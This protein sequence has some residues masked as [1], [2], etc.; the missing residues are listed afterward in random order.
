M[1]VAEDKS[2]EQVSLMTLHSAKGLEFDLVFLPGWEEEIFPSRRTLEENGIKGLEEERRL[3]YVGLTRAKKRVIISHV[4][5]RLV[6]GSWTHAIPSRFAAELPEQHV[7]RASESGM[8]GKSSGVAAFH[9][10]P[11]SGFT[12]G[13]YPP[14]PK[15]VVI[16]SKAVVIEEEFSLDFRKGDRVF[17][18]KFGYGTVTGRDGKKLDI[19]FDQAGTKKVMADF[20]VPEDQAG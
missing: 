9:P 12:K 17:H 13:H 5:S 1:D 14:R 16:D 7:Q 2:Q 15:P 10:A 20:V 4:A 3:A 8:F 11:S 18:Q 19:E 6:H